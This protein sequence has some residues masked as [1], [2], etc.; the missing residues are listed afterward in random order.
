MGYWVIGSKTYGESRSGRGLERSQGRRREWETGRRKGGGVER[1]A[2]ETSED[3]HIH[4][5]REKE[6]GG[7]ANPGGVGKGKGRQEGRE[8]EQ[9]RKT[10]GRGKELLGREGN[11]QR[12][13]KGKGGRQQS[14]DAGQR[15]L[16]EESMWRHRCHGQ[17]KSEQVLWLV[18][19]YL[20]IYDNVSIYTHIS[21]YGKYG[22]V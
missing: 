15:E 6:R 5:G 4:E 17:L 10:S 22:T 19:T 2:G 20:Y 18:N 12:E 13:P 11:E 16:A 1:Q 21:K 9:E 3:T 14:E 7:Y 8:K